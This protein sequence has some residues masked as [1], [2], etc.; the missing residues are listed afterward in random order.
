[1]SPGRSVSTGRL[2]EAVWYGE[3]PPEGAS[4]LPSYVTRLRRGLGA[5]RTMVESTPT[6][7][8]LH[9]DAEAVDAERYERLLEKA[10]QS[11]D[12]AEVLSVLEE[13]LGLWRGDAYEEFAHEEWARPESV[14]L[15]ESRAAATE[16][17]TEARL[18]LGSHEAAAGDLERWIGRWP[19]RERF[20]AQQMVALYRSGRQPEALRA[21]QDFRALLGEELGLDPSEELV[22]LERRVADWRRGVAD[23]I[24]SGS[25]PSR[26][27]AA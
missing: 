4:T 14:R 27:P 15:D 2:V 8:V 7:Y 12:T 5:D 13:A 20:R 22:E 21:Y 25:G 1:M 16:L 6:G 10:R 11:P 24:A 17:Y 18:D 9:V 26:V 3:E 19:L 23:A